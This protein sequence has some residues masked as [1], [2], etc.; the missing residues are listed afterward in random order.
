MLRLGDVIHCPE[1][2]YDIVPNVRIGGQM[3]VRLSVEGR[4]AA[5]AAAKATMDGAPITR[6]G[7]IVCQ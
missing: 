2:R 7:D 4:C 1:L 6:R 3:A 5:G